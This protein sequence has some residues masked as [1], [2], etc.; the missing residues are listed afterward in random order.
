M[1][2][3]TDAS[4]GMS[5]TEIG[6]RIRAALQTELTDDERDRLVRE[7]MLAWDL[8]RAVLRDLGVTDFS[9]FDERRAQGLHAHR[10]RLGLEE[11]WPSDLE[12]APAIEERWDG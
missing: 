5:G 1:K 10:Y 8:G 7:E 2:R 4:H 12:Q 3:V 11:A 6:N 9:R